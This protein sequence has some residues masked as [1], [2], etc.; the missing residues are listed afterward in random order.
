MAMQFTKSEKVDLLLVYGE[1]RK[2]SVAASNLYAERFPLRRHPNRNYFAS[3]EE[4]LRLEHHEPDEGQHFVVD[5]S[6]FRNLGLFNRNNLRY[7]AI[8]NPRVI[9]ESKYQERFGFNVWLGLLAIVNT[10]SNI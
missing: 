4:Q 6:I 5:E 9:R 8:D 7:W 3:L 2:N 1:C 10:Q